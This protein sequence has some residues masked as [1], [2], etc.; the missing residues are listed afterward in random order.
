ME[1]ADLV[2]E[3][4]KI[5]HNLLQLEEKNKHVLDHSIESDT[6]LMQY[7]NQVFVAATSL[8]ESPV[9]A[10]V[11]DCAMQCELPTDCGDQRCADAKGL[12]ASLKTTIEVLEAEL[13]CL[14]EKESR[15]RMREKSSEW[16]VVSRRTKVDGFCNPAG[17]PP[18]C[19]DLVAVV[20][21]SQGP[22]MLPP[23]SNAMSTRHLEQRIVTRLLTSS[24]V[25]HTLPKQPRLATVSSN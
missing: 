8:V 13:N 19:L 12:V 3:N 14:R 9:R 15:G 16:S 24:V 4:K 25:V 11:A 2:A 6:R 21:S 1:V 7:T 23:V 17:K 20:L 18:M 22:M 10:S 5:K